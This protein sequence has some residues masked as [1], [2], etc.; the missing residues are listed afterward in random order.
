[1]TV[2]PEPTV[3]GTTEHSAIEAFAT[4]QSDLSDADLRAVLADIL[5]TVQRIETKV[6]EAEQNIAIIKDVAA[7]A[8]EAMAQSPMLRMLGVRLPSS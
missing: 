2:Q 7:P 5:N 3:D 1:M 4:D 6:N 8:I